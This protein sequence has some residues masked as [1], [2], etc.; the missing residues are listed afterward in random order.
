MQEYE[1]RKMQTELLRELLEATRDL[2]AD[3]IILGQ[4]N[5]NKLGIK[6]KE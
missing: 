3:I 1:L 4:N 6:L 2:N 5:N